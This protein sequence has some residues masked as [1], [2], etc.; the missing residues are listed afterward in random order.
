M[1]VWSELTH[2][3]LVLKDCRVSAIFDMKSGVKVMYFCE[4]TFSRVFWFTFFHNIVFLCRQNIRIR[5]TSFPW[6][7]L[8]LA[9]LDNFW[10][11]LTFEA[12]ITLL[13]SIQ[14]WVSREHQTN[15]SVFQKSR[16]IA[17][18]QKVSE[19]LNFSSSHLVSKGFVYTSKNPAK[20]PEVK[21]F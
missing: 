14:Y 13:V 12:V 5:S 11:C 15:V 19:Q 2:K 21:K 8:I 18:S 1:T 6:I 4:P 9:F 10:L 17:E 7:A 16:Q 20:S 3:A